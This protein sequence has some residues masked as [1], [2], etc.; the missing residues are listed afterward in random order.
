LRADPASRYTLVMRMSYAIVFVR[1]MDEAVR[2]YRDV[3]GLPLRFESPHW[4]EFETGEATLALHPSREADEPAD[5]PP[6]RCRPGFRVQD[7]DAFHDRMRAA[8]VRCVEEPAV[9][10]GTRMAQYEDPD[11]LPFSVAE[12]PGGGA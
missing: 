10:F 8:G 5:L 2:F 7:L 1:D 3:V 11:G 12:T 6:G 9:V 4:S